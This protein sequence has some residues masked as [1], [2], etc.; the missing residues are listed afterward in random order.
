MVAKDVTKSRRRKTGSKASR[1]NVK[2]HMES[3]YW[4][5]CDVGPQEGPQ[6]QFLKSSAD[7]VIYGG[8]AGGGKSWALLYET[9]RNVDVPGFGAVI[10]R[11]ESTQ[12]RA[13]GGLWDMAL[14]MY[15]KWLG[16][17]RE[18]PMLDWRFP[19]GA[20]IHFAHMQ[21]EN[22]R[23]S[24]D[25]SQIALICFDQLESFT[26]K[27]FTYM[28]S[29]NRTM[30]GVQP[31]IRAT[32]N[33]NPDHF[34]RIL[35]LDWWIDKKTGYAISER[36][37]IIRWFV[38][39]NNKIHW[40]D[41]AEEIKNKFGED[42]DPKSFTFIPSSIYDNK[43]LLKANPGYIANLKKLPLIDRERLLQG[44]WNIRES[45]GMF[46]QRSW[47][48]IVNAAPSDSERVRYWDRAA[49]DESVA[50][51]KGSHTAGV[52]MSRNRSTGLFYIENV[53]RFQKSAH[54][55]KKTI[56]NVATQDGIAIRVGIEQDPGQAGKAEA[57]DQVRN[58]AGYNVIINTVRESKGIRARP[59]SAQCE[60]G[61]VKI[62]RG[63]WNEPFLNELQ[64]FDGSDNCVSDQVD[65]ASGAFH[66]LT[67]VKRAGVWGK[68]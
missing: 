38:H 8:Q 2:R 48:E 66:L 34:L 57:Q 53:E 37:G 31:Y 1:A 36:S 43:I 30:C 61:N 32:C 11:R 24:W 41:T 52:L 49:T 18:S 27:Q 12:I 19:S 68:R 39:I 51:G 13:E 65:A 47:F 26:W 10:F 40:A 55:V 9:L 56:K 5:G 54:G 23:F 6:D 21:H 50:K 67:N 17:P 22:D 25:G 35:F 29:R 44:N 7:I 3:A 4:H 16:V 28:L 63:D 20:R 64:N 62:V 15:P 60:A 58:L 42:S 46:F 33:P 59:L 45:A 14:E